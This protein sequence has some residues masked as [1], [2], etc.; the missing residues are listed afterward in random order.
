MTSE[1]AP[2]PREL[3]KRLPKI[4]LHRAALGKSLLYPGDDSI[5]ALACDGEPPP[6]I[7]LPLLDLNTQMVLLE[8]ARLYSQTIYHPTGT[9][10]M[11]QDGMAVVDERLR[12]H[13]IA[14][15]RVVDASI[16][17]EIVSGNT[18]A[19]TIMIGEKASDM[20]IEDARS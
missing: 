17:P 1:S 11:G 8:A 14:G 16:M 15:L 19:P 2:R 4:E 10:K 12:V 13:G 3:Y 20:I 7:S 9:C 18:N 6:G 5:I